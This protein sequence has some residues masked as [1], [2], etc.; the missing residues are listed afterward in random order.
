M[1]AEILGDLGHRPYAQ[2]DTNTGR[3]RSHQRSAIQAK[4]THSQIFVQFPVGVHG[5]R[6]PRSI[7]G[8]TELP[9]ASSSRHSHLE[10]AAPKRTKFRIRPMKLRA[11]ALAG[12][13]GV[14]SVFIA[15][16]ATA[17]GYSPEGRKNCDPQGPLPLTALNSISLLAVQQQGERQCFAVCYGCLLRLFNQRHC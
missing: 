11:V 6:L 3:E 14:N 17:D 5:G 8:P 1:F 15:S 2:Q 16:T 7:H 10:S 12:S 9:A 4:F 13:I